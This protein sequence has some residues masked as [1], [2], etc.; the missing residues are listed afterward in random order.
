[1]IHGMKLFVTFPRVL[2]NKKTRIIAQVNKRKLKTKTCS[3][4]KIWEK[5]CEPVMLGFS[6]IS[7]WITKF[8]QGF[9]RIVA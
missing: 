6:F 8:R 9:N 4:R 7:D 5:V 3:R 2:Q 1:M